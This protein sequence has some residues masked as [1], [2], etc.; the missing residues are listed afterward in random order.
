M[1]GTTVKRSPGRKG[2][3]QAEPKSKLPQTVAEVLNQH[4]VLETESIDRM[5][6]N[7][8]VGRLQILEGAL[9]FIRQQRQA[10]VLSTSAV[11][12]HSAKQQAPWPPGPTAQSNPGEGSKAAFKSRRPP[13]N[14]RGHQGTLGSPESGCGR[15]VSKERHG[16]GST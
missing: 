1:S 3:P 2:T 14:H 4:V 9:H 12:L 8:I 10:K 6:W 7:V 15:P 13:E 5:Y 11:E 16:S